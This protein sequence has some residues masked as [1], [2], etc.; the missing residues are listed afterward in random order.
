MSGYRIS[1][2]Y[3]IIDK[4]IPYFLLIPSLII[5]GIVLIYPLIN[6]VLLSF[7][8]Y[9]LIN[10]IYKFVGLRNFYEII[11]SSE[12]WD[13]FGNTI[14]ILFT[15]VF[16]QFLF[17]FGIA[18]ALNR[19]FSGKN[20]YR[21]L[22]FLIWVI[23]E[24]VVALL[25]MIIYNSDFGILN[26]FLQKLGI[27]DGNLYWL[28]APLP[29]KFAL[30]I[31]YSWRGIPFFMVMNLAAMQTIPQTIVEAAKIDGANAVKRF[32]I[33]TIPFIKDLLGLS[34]LLSIVRLFQDVTQ[35]MTLTNGGPVNATT[36]LA[37]NVYKR[38]FV[39]FQMGPAAAVGVT[40][41]IFLVVLAAFY[42]KSLTRGEQF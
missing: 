39:S 21:G 19:N 41:L 17:G 29:A 7:T 30:I 9:S 27:I 24:I 5:A 10:P 15:S 31:D 42:I 38:A 33:I 25:W 3:N 1:T 14:F 18:L 16:F 11:T 2:S 13:I 35:I 36:T 22:I 40:W 34:I 12:Y 20:I 4:L 26:F 37:L 23:P 8:S 32:F 28:G 6:G